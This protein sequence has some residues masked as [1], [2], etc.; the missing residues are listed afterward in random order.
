MV[1]RQ[2]P[3]RTPHLTA[4]AQSRGYRRGNAARSKCGDT[5]GGHCLPGDGQPDP[6]RAGTNVTATVW[7]ATVSEMEE[8]GQPGQVCR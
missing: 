3:V 7:T 1:R 2:H 8:Q 4:M 6:G 5:A